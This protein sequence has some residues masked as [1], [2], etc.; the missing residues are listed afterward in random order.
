MEEWHQTIRVFFVLGVIQDISY[1]CRH[2]SNKDSL[3]LVFILSNVI[4]LITTLLK[5]PKH[6][7]TRA[8][9]LDTTEITLA[10]ERPQLDVGE[11]VKYRVS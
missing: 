4:L 6:P 9:N 2:I 8:R 1:T 11:E 3:N 10:W 5:E 7:I